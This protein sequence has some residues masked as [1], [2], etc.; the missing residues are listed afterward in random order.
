MRKS[1]LLSATALSVMLAFSAN[2]M[3]AQNLD[4]IS[5]E[6]LAKAVVSV[7]KKNPKIA[8]DAVA[9]FHKDANAK[10]AEAEKELTPLEKRVAD[11]LMDNPP[12]VVGALQIYQQQEEQQKL[13][14]QA[15]KY[16]KYADEINKADLYAGNPNGKYV[17]V[18]F[19]DFCTDGVNQMGFPH[20]RSAIEEQGVEDGF[21][22][23]ECYGFGNTA[24]Q[25]VAFTF[26]KCVKVVFFVQMRVNVRRQGSLRNL[27]GLYIAGRQ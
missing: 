8:Y 10:K 2:T 11:I 24:R 21:G 27:F 12:I 15:E 13:L 3:A 22:W 9:A 7:L 16:E 17:L 26:N 25:L 6:E 23:V 18:E 20:A 4:N 5:D 14:E 1:K 19:F